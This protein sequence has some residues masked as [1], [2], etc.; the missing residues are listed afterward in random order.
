MVYRV[1][2]STLGRHKRVSDRGIVPCAPWGA[3]PFTFVLRGRM[4]IPETIL[5]SPSLK[6]EW[7]T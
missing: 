2:Q 7:F 3:G 6:A 5:K 1:N 4:A